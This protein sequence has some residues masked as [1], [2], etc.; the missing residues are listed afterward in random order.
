MNKCLGE[1]RGQSTGGTDSRPQ[2]CTIRRNRY[3]VR[4]T[5]KTE[6][7]I[8]TCTVRSSG[9]SK[10]SQFEGLCGVYEGKENEMPRTVL[11]RLKNT[12]I[13]LGG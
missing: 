7:L 6:M 11:L 10:L 2:I 12:R 1:L 9:P 13:A 5:S 4:A 3:E 8:R